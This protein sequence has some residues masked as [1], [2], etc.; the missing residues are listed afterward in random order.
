MY[1]S[2]INLKI[3]YKINI[4]LFKLMYNIKNTVGI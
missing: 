3:N 4:N 2:N 1:I